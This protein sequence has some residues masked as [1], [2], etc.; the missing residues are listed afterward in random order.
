MVES[1]DAKVPDAVIRRRPT[2]GGTETFFL[3]VDPTDNQYDTITY[4][5]ALEPSSPGK[6]TGATDGLEVS[7]TP[8]GNL[9]VGVRY[10]LTFRVTIMVT[11]TGTMAEADTSD[12]RV[13]TGAFYG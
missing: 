1:F 5:W 11:G 13:I 6:L 12:M 4:A 2:T 3:D 7:Y 10:C 9:P 8:L